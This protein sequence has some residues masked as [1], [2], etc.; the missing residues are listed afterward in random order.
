MLIHYAI[1]GEHHED[2]QAGVKIEAKFEAMLARPYAKYFGVELFPT[3]FDKACCYY[4]TIVRMHIFFNGNKR[5][6]LSVFLVLLEINNYTLNVEDIFLEDYTVKIAHDEHDCAEEEV[7]KIVEE[8]G[9]FLVH[10][11]K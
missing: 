1:M 7:A 8:L 4:H 10:G 6:A 11:D 3:L 5:T 2:N 9:L